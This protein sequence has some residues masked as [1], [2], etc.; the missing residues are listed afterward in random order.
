MVL[1]GLVNIGKKIGYVRQNETLTL[2]DAIDIFSSKTAKTCCIGQS[3]GCICARY[4]L[5][6]CST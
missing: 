6:V 1:K 5:S 2:K 3:A 4:R